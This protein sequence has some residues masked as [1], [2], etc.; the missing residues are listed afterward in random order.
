MTVWDRFVVKMRAV[1]LAFTLVLV[2]TAGADY[3]KV[4]MKVRNR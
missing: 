4:I 1:V 2:L 3:H